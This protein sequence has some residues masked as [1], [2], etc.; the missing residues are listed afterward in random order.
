VRE[1]VEAMFAIIGSLGRDL[2]KGVK[3]ERLIGG[4]EVSEKGE[5]L[6][7][8]PLEF[9]DLGKRYIL[10][11]FGSEYRYGS[12]KPIYRTNFAISKLSD[13]AKQVEY[14]IVSSWGV[15]CSKNH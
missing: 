11:L 3:E 4:S 14:S 13:W 9:G 12:A 15:C 2:W 1:D 10:S 7:R 5:G 8:D 6:Y